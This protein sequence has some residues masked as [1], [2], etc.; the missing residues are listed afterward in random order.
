MASGTSS[1][2]PHKEDTKLSLECLRMKVCIIFYTHIVVFLA[3][4]CEIDQLSEKTLA[5][6]RQV[7]DID[8]VQ[9]QKDIMSE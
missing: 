1:N 5:G 6:T 4:D 8:I 7:K 3:S 9:D 2:I